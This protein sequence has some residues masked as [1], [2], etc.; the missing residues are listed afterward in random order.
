MLTQLWPPSGADDPI[1]LAAL[2]ASD[3]RPSPAD[4]PWVMLNM[5]A[6]VD[7]AIAI[8]NLSGGLGGPADLAVFKAIRA[9]PDAIVAGSSTVIA[10]DYGP[11][12][13]SGPVKQARLER[14]QQPTP[15]IVVLSKSLRLA[16]TA[17]LFTNNPTR[18]IIYTD[19]LAAPDRRMALSAVADVVSA[20]ADGVDL[21]Q[22][23]DDM[24]SRGMRT[25]L[26]EGGPSV[27]AQFFALDLVD[28]LC[29]T[30]SPM[31]VGGDGP[32]II[33]AAGMR[34]QQ[35]SLDRVLMADGMLFSRY[36]VDRN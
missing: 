36:L 1:D 10:E 22:A 7:G 11:A 30:T 27:N 15:P 26:V 2:Y 5:I 16:P 3:H 18:P 17:R 9:V 21:H 24:Y 34:P 14:G 6:S 13:P 31:L 8:D 33:A 4:R 19:Q 32:G 25:V 23:L 29:L 20:G 35:L 12:L 28:E